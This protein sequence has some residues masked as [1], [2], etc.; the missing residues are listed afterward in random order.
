MLANLNIPNLEQVSKKDPKL[1]EA[2]KK[3]QTYINANVTPTPGNKQTAP[4]FVSPTR[5]PG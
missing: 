5:V 4:T 3:V 2:L 1:G